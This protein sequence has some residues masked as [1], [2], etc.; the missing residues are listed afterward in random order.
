MAVAMIERPSWPNQPVRGHNPQG[1]D[2]RDRAQPDQ[3]P[4]Q[5]A[6]GEMAWLLRNTRSSMFLG[7]GV[8]SAI[9]IAIGLEAAFS[10]HAMRPGVLGVVNVGL[11]SGLLLC[12][13]AAVIMLAVA[14]RPVHN[15]LS[16]M[17]WKTGAPIDPRAGWLT[18][19]P[20]GSDPE[21]WTWA[22]AHLLL[23]A[24][25]LARRRTQVAD[26]WTYIAAACFLLWTVV[27]LLGL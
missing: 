8:L 23:S 27:I 20:A 15:V 21:E 14:N 12:W 3:G 19:P 2:L 5:E 17:R 6:I 11:L 7:G 13:L 4:V 18:L 9:T 26:T 22:R 1:R 24:A 25:R 10:G 16:E